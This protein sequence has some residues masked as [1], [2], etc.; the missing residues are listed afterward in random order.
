MQNYFAADT[1][2]ALAVSAV[3]CGEQAWEDIH[4]ADK[5][6]M[7][8]ETAESLLK[9]KGM[10]FDAGEMMVRIEAAVQ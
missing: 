2:R 4:A 6:R 5:V 8:R 9:K 3:R 1:K 10:P 7:A